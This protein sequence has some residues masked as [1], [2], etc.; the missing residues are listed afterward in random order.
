MRQVF[1]RFLAVALFIAVSARAQDVLDGIAAVVN[2]DVI[3]FSQ[4]REL[5]GARERS[6]RS[7][8]KGEELVKEVRAVRLAALDDLID[9]QLILQEFKKMEEK[10][11]KIPDFAIDERIQQII[12]EDFGGDRQAFS[13]TLEAQ[14][15]TLSRFRELEREKIVVQA[16]RQ[17]AIRGNIVISPG[18]IE[19]YYAKNRDRW[20]D[21]EQVRIRMIVLKAGGEDESGKRQMAEEIRKKAKEGASFEQLAMMYTEDGKQDDGGDWGWITRKSLNE[22]LTKVAFNLRAGEVSQV[23]EMDGR[24]YLIYCEARKNASVAPLEEKR[25]E[26][27]QILEQEERQKLQQKWI[28]GLRSKAYI[29]TF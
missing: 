9:R 5:V 8:L 19:A 4:V 20:T 15:Y 1:F 13:R 22:N 25:E 12:R 21:P 27:R 10:G 23:L 17:N 7:Q 6:L 2:G 18:D 16:V 14:G 28:A 29:K 11:A 26:I 24:F 3:T